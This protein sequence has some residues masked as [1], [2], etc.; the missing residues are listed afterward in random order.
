[1]QPWK[2]RARQ[3]ILQPARGKYLTVENHTVELPNGAVI[4]D[5]PWL[6]TPDYVNVVA[7]TSSHEFICFR[8][9]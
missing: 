2:T 1:M 9:T 7:V 4:D 8:Q 6:I 5:W 3:T